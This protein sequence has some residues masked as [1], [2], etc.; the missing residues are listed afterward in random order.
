MNIK[1][2]V[3]LVVARKVHAAQDNLYRAERQ[4]TGMDSEELKQ[5]YRASGSSCQQVLDSY[6]SAAADAQLQLDWVNSREA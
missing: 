1:D 6:K 2:K 4:F 3:L 5:P